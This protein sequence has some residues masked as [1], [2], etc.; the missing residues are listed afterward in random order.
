[1]QPNNRLGIPSVI[2]VDIAKAL[3]NLSGYTEA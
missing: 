2:L 1:M 3:N